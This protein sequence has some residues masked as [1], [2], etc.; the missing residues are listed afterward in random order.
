MYGLLFLIEAWL[1]P[2]STFH[3]LSVWRVCL[4]SLLHGGSWLVCQVLPAI[5]AV[6]ILELAANSGGSRMFLAPGLHLAT[7]LL[8][9]TIEKSIYQFNIPLNLYELFLVHVSTV[10]IQKGQWDGKIEYN[11]IP[12][13]YAYSNLKLGEN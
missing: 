7:Q 1:C 12:L 13:S 9:S 3:Y 2:A 5:G 11:I 6:S 10:K 8:S 4:S